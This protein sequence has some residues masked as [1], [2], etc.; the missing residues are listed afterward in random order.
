M[1][2]PDEYHFASA[3]T[4]ECF[5]PESGSGSGDTFQL[6]SRTETVDL[7]EGSLSRQLD[8]VL[9]LEP[10]PVVLIHPEDAIHLDIADKDYVKASNSTGECELMARLSQTVPRG[11]IAVSATVPETRNLFQW[12]CDDEEITAQADAITLKKHNL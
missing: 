9:S 10:I 11:T 8:W 4:A 12:R 7:F 5:E 2:L 6:I 1:Q 3:D